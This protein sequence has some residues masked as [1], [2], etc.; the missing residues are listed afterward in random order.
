MLHA[1]LAHHPSTPSPNVSGIDVRVSLQGEGGLRLTYTLSGN[2]ARLLIPAPAAPA[3]REGLWR[4]TCFEVFIMAGHGPGY[5]EFNFSPS[6]D[7]AAYGF[8]GYRNGGP[9]DPAPEPAIVCRAGDGALELEAHLVRFA[10]PDGRRLRLGLSAVVEGPDG[11]LAY[12][13]L[14][15]PPGKPDFH[16]TDA[17]ALPLDRT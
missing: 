4:H 6:G 7:W 16:H 5:R 13:A 9:L 1:A 12:W 14:R 8:Q 2:L 11:K 10:L 3:R 17:F 15:H